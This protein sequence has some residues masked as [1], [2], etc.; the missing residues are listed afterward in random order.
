[1][2][3]GRRRRHGPD[4]MRSGTRGGRSYHRHCCYYC[5]HYRTAIVVVDIVVGRGGI[6]GGGAGKEEGRVYD[7]SLVTQVKAKWAK[8]PSWLRWLTAR[9]RYLKATTRERWSSARSWPA[10]FHLLGLMLTSSSS[11]SSLLS[12]SLP[13]F[14]PSFRH[15][16]P[17]PEPAHRLHDEQLVDTAP[18]S[19]A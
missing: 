13:P 12:H 2:R 19:V 3:T 11:P 7:T 8:G 9:A 5:R 15:F 10:V 6:G 4:G 16:E 17:E 18:V 14:L 1:M